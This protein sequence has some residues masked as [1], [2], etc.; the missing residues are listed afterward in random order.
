MTNSARYKW[1]TNLNCAKIAPLHMMH[2]VKGLLALLFKLKYQHLGY[3]LMLPHLPMVK[4]TIQMSIFYG[5]WVS[6]K[7]HPFERSQFNVWWVSSKTQQSIDRSPISDIWSAHSEAGE[8][9]RGSLLWH[10]PWPEVFVRPHMLFHCL[11]F[12]CQCA[13]LCLQS[14]PPLLSQPAKRKKTEFL[15]CGKKPLEY[16]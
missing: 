11:L 8:G 6:S 9:N 1:Y 2:H 16:V 12:Y 10:Q 4:F 14:T 13:P 3:W 7:T 15:Q 5:W